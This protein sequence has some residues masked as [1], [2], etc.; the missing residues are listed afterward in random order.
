MFGFDG[1]LALSC[2]RQPSGVP[3]ELALDH[4]FQHLGLTVIEPSTERS[5]AEAGRLY[6]EVCAPLLT[7]PASAIDLCVSFLAARATQARE[8]RPA[9]TPRGGGDDLVVLWFCESDPTPQ[10]MDLVATQEDAVASSGLGRVVWVS[11]FIAT[12]PGTEM[13]MDEL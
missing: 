10:W 8:H 13:Y 7:V 5:P 12:V 6:T 9:E 3:A 1:T 4:R 2:Q 11:P